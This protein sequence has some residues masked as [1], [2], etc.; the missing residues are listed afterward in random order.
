MEMRAAEPAGMEDSVLALCCSAVGRGSNCH[1]APVLER[2]RFWHHGFINTSVGASR[3][4]A[5]RR[6]WRRANSSKLL[7]PTWKGSRGCQPARKGANC[8][9]RGHLGLTA[10]KRQAAVEGQKCRLPVVVGSR[11]L[12]DERRL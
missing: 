5:W 8:R 3:M 10:E 11:C 2:W 4:A 7:S 9:R 12:V 1:S 6:W